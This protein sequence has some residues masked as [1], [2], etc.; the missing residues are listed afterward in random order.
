MNFMPGSGVPN[1]TTMHGVLL[2]AHGL[3][4]LLTGPA[5]IG[6]STLALELLARGHALVADDAVSVRRSGSKLEGHCDPLLRGQL[7]V[8][9]LGLLDVGKLYGAGALR[10]RQRLDLV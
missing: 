6:K 1:V 7:A 2:C 3:G 8:R 10:A 9:E 5:G 4:V